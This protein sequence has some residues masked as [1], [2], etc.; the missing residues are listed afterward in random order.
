MEKH[1]KAPICLE[2]DVLRLEVPDLHVRV[3]SLEQ[4]ERP[5][6]GLHALRPSLDR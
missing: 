3:V 4:L 2:T 6:E 1:L 5:M